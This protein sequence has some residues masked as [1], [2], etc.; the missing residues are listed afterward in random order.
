[1]PMVLPAPGRFLDDDRL[2]ELAPRP[3]PSPGATS[4]RSHCRGSGGRSG[5]GLVGQACADDLRPRGAWAPGGSRLTRWP[6][7]VTSETSAFSSC[8]VL[9]WHGFLG[10]GLLGTR[11]ALGAA[12]A[13]RYIMAAPCRHATSCA[14]PTPGST[15]DQNGSVPRPNFVV[16]RV[17]WRD[18]SRAA[19]PRRKSALADLRES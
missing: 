7:Q 8:G 14:G 5:I 18:I 3:D 2:S 6:R 16:R 1:M 11:M 15:R 4:R 17:F 12:A 9:V 13:A 19:R 10:Y